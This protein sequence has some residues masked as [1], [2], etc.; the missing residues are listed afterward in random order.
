[1]HSYKGIFKGEKRVRKT[2]FSLLIPDPTRRRRGVLFLTI[3][4]LL[5][6]KR[7]FCYTILDVNLRCFMKINDY[8]DRNRLRDAG[9]LYF[10]LVA[11]YGF[12]GFI[13]A[14]LIV[15]GV[16]Y[17]FQII[18]I[19]NMLIYAKGSIFTKFRE[20]DKVNLSIALMSILTLGYI[21]GDYVVIIAFSLFIFLLFFLVF[22]FQHRRES[23]D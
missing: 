15:S 18:I 21:I 1:M 19:S 22:Y 11:L 14:T 12:G 6:F 23:R 3:L 4:S 2:R 9:W 7:N 10:F 16:I 13:S 17:T 20:V 5:K 8:I